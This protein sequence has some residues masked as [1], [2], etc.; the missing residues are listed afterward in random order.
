MTTEGMGRG[1]KKKGGSD[2][3]GIIKASGMSCSKNL[4][5]NYEWH[6]IPTKLLRTPCPPPH[7]PATR[8]IS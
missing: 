4:P 6:I 1:V 2:F 8:E 5:Q 3:S 7:L